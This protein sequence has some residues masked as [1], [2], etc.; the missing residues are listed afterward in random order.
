MLDK[1]LEAMVNNGAGGTDERVGVHVTVSATE[2]QPLTV[3]V[4]D[5]QG[6]VGIGQTATAVQSARS[7]QVDHPHSHVCLTSHP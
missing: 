7:K 5:E 4:R 2:G 1:K 6:R 3:Q